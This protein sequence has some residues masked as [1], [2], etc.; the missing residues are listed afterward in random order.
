MRTAQWMVTVNMPDGTGQVRHGYLSEGVGDGTHTLQEL[1]ERHGPTFRERL[2][3]FS[4]AGVGRN[5]L[6]DLRPRYT[7]RERN[8]SDQPVDIGAGW[9]LR[10]RAFD[11]CESLLP[12]YLNR[13]RCGLTFIRSGVDERADGSAR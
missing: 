12:E 6:I 13:R 7:P 1:L 9:L 8:G 10:C 3:R 5:D 4:T 2:E 11:E